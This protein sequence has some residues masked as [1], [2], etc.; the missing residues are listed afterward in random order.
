MLRLITLI[1]S[2][3]FMILISSLDNEVKKRNIDQTISQMN[4]NS[5]GEIIPFSATHERLYKAAW[6]MFLDKPIF[7]LGTNL[8]RQNCDKSKY[9][10][11]PS[12][13]TH[14]HNTYLQILAETG[15]IGFLFLI[16]ALYYF[17][18]NI[19]IHLLFKYRRKQYFSDFEICLL[20]G[21]IIYLWPIIPTGN[22]FTNWLSILM[23]IN[24]PFLIWSRNL[25]KSKMINI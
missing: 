8:F 22:F 2:V 10:E 12:C 25:S 14:P 9:S 3:I 15:L 24:L 21:I 16:I 7:G 19:I 5:E 13:S 6:K 4:L 20:S 18:K 1:F 11:G 23:F 17:C